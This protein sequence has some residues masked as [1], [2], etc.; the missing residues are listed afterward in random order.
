MAHIRV[1]REGDREEVPLHFEGLVLKP[2]A[3]CVGWPGAAILAVAG[4]FIM[5]SHAGTA[6]ELAGAPAA[7]GG[8]ILMVALYRCRRFEAVAGRKWLKT[9]LGPFRQDLPREL[10]I[11]AAARRA[12]GWR[13][14][15]ADQEMVLDLSVGTR[16]PLLPSA[17]PEAMIE[18][19]GM[20]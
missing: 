14:L 7:A 11:G 8:G 17:D 6:F 4:V 3:R 15:Y 18:A 10:I 12:T 1:A 9:R 19:L 20:S 5:V 13:R 16:N 2:V